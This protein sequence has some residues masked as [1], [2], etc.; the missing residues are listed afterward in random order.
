MEASEKSTLTAENTYVHLCSLQ[1]YTLILRSNERSQQDPH[2]ANLL[3]VNLL[4]AGS[5]AET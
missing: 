3:H 4:A 1:T 2:E 5:R